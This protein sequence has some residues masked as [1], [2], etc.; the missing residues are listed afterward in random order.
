VLILAREFLITGLRQIAIESG[1]VLAADRLGKWKTG[2]Q[3]GFCIT[4]LVWLAVGPMAA[5]NPLLDLLRFLSAPTS[6]LQPA[7][8]WLALV[9]TLVSGW[10]YLWAARGMLR[11][12]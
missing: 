1:Q 12:K 2:M 9:L 8:L 5:G 3:L 6:W 10:S 11:A 7:F 4:C